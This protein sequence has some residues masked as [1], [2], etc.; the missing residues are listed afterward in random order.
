MASTP[1]TMSSDMSSMDKMFVKKAA[2][3]GMFEVQTGQIAASKGDSQDVKDFGNKM[4]AD[5]GKANDELKG[6]VT[7]MNMQTPDALDAKHQKMVD[8]LNAKSGPAFDKA[9]MADMSKAHSMDDALF[10]KEASSGTNPQLKDFA[11]KTDMV[12]KQH[13]QMID[14]MKSKMM[15]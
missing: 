3:G 5:H 12:V 15:K 2:M 9:Y 13:I 10:M 14:D 7:S 4:V 6:I 1:S 8:A 11:S